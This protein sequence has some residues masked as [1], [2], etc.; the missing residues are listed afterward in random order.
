MTPTT[1]TLSGSRY[2]MINP[3]SSLCLKD[4]S[5]PFYLCFP[6]CSS[7][8][9]YF[10]H[11]LSPFRC[12]WKHRSAAKQ[13]G[14]WFHSNINFAAGSLTTVM[15]RLIECSLKMIFC[16]WSSR[17]RGPLSFFSKILDTLFITLPKEWSFLFEGLWWWNVCVNTFPLLHV[18]LDYYW[19]P[20]SYLSSPYI[21]FSITFFFSATDYWLD[22]EFCWNQ[23]RIMTITEWCNLGANRDSHS[24]ENCK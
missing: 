2:D 11:F 14:H 16:W 10:T 20:N 13:C 9:D 8:L 3:F 15:V 19:R 1:A 17:G 22:K 7:A 18:D 23:C 21:T 6:I 4:D 12:F 5:I 24:G